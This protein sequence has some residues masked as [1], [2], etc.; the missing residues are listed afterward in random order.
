MNDNQPNSM[1][2]DNPQ[3]MSWPATPVKAPAQPPP[4][5]VRFSS[6]HQVGYQP[7]VQYQPARKY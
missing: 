4:Q 7:T 6:P 1:Y 2:S 3:Q 5:L